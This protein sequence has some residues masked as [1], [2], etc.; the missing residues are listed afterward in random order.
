MQGKA[1]LLDRVEARDQEFREWCPSPVAWSFADVVEHL[2]LVEK[3]LL[4]ALARDPDVTRPRRWSRWRRLRW[5]GLRVAL[6]AGVRFTAPTELI[7]PTRELQW[8]ALLARWEDQRR[9]LEEWLRASDPKIHPRPRFRHPFIG[10]LDVPEAIAFAADH[11]EH[12]LRQVA[13]I[14]HA[15]RT[16]NDLKSVKESYTA[17]K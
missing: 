8:H 14:E 10:W 17:V 16:Y 11:L 5:I 15:Y 3:H 7:L 12:H 2:E 9:A 4:A 1:R 6:K 13:R